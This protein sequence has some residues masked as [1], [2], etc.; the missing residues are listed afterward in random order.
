M[1][2]I[3]PLVHIHGLP[4]VEIHLQDIYCECILRNGLE[5]GLKEWPRNGLGMVLEWSRNGLGMV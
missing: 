2:H 3:L 1:P 4:F 5:M